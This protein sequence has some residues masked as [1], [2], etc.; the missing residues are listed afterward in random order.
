[1]RILLVEDTEDL[2]KALRQHFLDE[3]HAV[4]W[5]QTGPDAE[6]FLHAQNYDVI[7]LDLGVPGLSGTEVLKALRR[8]RDATPVLVMTARSAIEDKLAHFDFGADDYLLKPFD[9]REL[10]ARLNALM[11]RLNGLAASVVRFGNFTFDG[12]AKRVTV[13]GQAVD[14]G[15]REFR[16]LEYFVSTR[17]RIASKEQIL[18]RLFSMD[19]EVGLNAIE[20]YVS[21]LRRKLEG[22][23]FTIRTIRGLGYVAEIDGG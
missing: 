8:R 16:L 13:D 22:S 12:G 6:A 4:D 21:R 20:L 15:R 11:R 1:M 17:G 14:L 19:A 5:A 3:G 2:G 23:Q 10:D 9:F 7:L 18:D